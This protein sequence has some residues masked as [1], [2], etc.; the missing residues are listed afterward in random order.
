MAKVS[1]AVALPPVAPFGSRILSREAMAAEIRQLIADA[2]EG[3]RAACAGIVRAKH[4]LMY[5]RDYD[6]GV[7]SHVEDIEEEILARGR[8]T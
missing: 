8:K 4:D 7:L 1:K 3:E 6:A 5:E 2:V